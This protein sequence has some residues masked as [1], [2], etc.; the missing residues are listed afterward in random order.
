MFMNGGMSIK[1]IRTVIECTYYVC[2][3]SQKRNLIWQCT[4]LDIK[5]SIN[6]CM[7]AVVP[8]C[9]GIVWVVEI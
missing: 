9:V 7:V 5:V 6:V 4:R 8:L 2:M 3:F 1:Q